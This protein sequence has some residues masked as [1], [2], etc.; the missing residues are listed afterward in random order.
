MATHAIRFN[1]TS[2]RLL[3]IFTHI[4]TGNCTSCS[5]R[6]LFSEDNDR[7]S[8]FFGFQMPLPTEDGSQHRALSTACPD[9]LCM[10]FTCAPQGGTVGYCESKWCPPNHCPING[11]CVSCTTN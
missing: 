9:G 1:R 11:E 10:R 6:S 7:S 8:P 4:I 3:S 2:H 5:R